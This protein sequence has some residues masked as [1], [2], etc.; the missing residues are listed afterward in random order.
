MVLSPQIARELARARIERLQADGA[1]RP[2]HAGRARGRR[3]WRLVV[4]GRL[5]RVGHRL[6]DSA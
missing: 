3:G 2:R 5:V 1:E 6:T 4:G